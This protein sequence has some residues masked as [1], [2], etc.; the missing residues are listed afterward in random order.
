MDSDAVRP[1]PQFVDKLF[2]PP[3]PRRLTVSDC[4]GANE[5]PAD[6]AALFDPRPGTVPG[7]SRKLSKL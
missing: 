7:C 5:S 6:Q 3:L 1:G 4:T 2:E